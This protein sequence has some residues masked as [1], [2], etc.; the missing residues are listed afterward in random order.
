LKLILLPKGVLIV[1]NDSGEST[2][3]WLTYL[4]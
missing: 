2:N 3:Y 4:S 1:V